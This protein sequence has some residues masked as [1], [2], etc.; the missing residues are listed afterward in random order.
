MK[1]QTFVRMCGVCVILQG[2]LSLAQVTTGTI[3]GTVTDPTGAVIPG[4]TITVRNVETGITRI[5]STDAA[6]RYTA[7]QLGLGG[8]E[9]TAGTAGFQ[10]TVR[11]G[12]ELTVGRQAVVDFTLRVGAVAETVTVTGEAPLLETTNATVADL[13]TESQM[14]DLPLN[15]RSFTNL[16]ALQ[17]GVVTDL[18]IPQGVF[19][20]G[21]R[22]SLNGARPQQSL[23]LLD[24]TDIVAPYSN[25]APVSV[26]F[27]ALGV[28]TIREFSV[29][30]N[31]Y[32]AQYGRAVGGI[33]SAVTR[34]GT[35]QLHGSLFEFLRNE[36]LDAKNFFDLPD[37]P[38]PPFKRNQFGGTIG[39]PIVRDNTFFFFSY[40]GL[41]QVL[42]TTDFGTVFSDET[43]LG[44]ITG[45]P[46][47]QS[48][49]TKE[50]AVVQNTV[51]VNPDIQPLI[52]IV[53]RGNGRY[54][55]DGIQEFLGSRL[56]RGRESYYMF[57]IDQRI[58]DNDSLFGRWTGDHSSKEL[59]DAQFFADGS[60]RHTSTDD[61][62]FYGFLTVEWTRIISPT[63][64]N[65]ARAG[66][67][68]NN[69]R[70]CMCIEGT[71]IGVNEISHPDYPVGKI[72]AQLQIIPGIP[73]GGPWG[74]PGVDVPG[75]HNGIGRHTEG[76]DLDDPL[77]Y[78][79]NTFTF[80][81]SVRIAR[82][83]HS[84][85]IG[86]DVRRY[87]ENALQSVWGKGG[88][89]FRSP[90]RNFLTTGRPDLCLEGGTSSRDCRGL[91]TLTATGI[92]RPPDAYRG[93]RQTYTAFFIQDD[94]QLRS[95][96]TLNFGIRWEQITGPTEVNQK[97]ATILD[98]LRDE[99][100]TQLGDKPLFEMRDGLKGFSPRFGFA[101]SPDQNTSIR[102]GFGAFREMPLLY[103]Y[104]L[105]VF[106]PPFSDRLQIR[107]FPLDAWPNPLAG[108]DPAGARR[109]PLTVNHDYKY[110]YSL[111][112]NLGI[113][114]QIGQTW[115][116]KVGYVGTRGISLVSINNL[117]QPAQELD[118]Q[119]VPFTPRNAPSP[120]PAI[121][122]TRS[123]GNFGDSW[124]N[125]LQL[126][127]Q[128]RF[129]YGI[130]F[131]LG[132]TWSKNIGDTGIGL[133]G[134]ETPGGDSQQ[135]GSLWDWKTLDRSL[136]AQDTRHNFTFNFSYDLPIGQGR[137]FGGNMGSVANAI[138]GGWQ[139]N[140]IFR[141]R[142]GLPMT[143]SGGGYSRNS[144]CRTCEIRPNLKPG[145]DNN[146]VRDNWDPNAPTL[147][148]AYFDVTQFE[149]VPTSYYG[150]VGKHT[151][152][153]P[154]LTTVDFSIF[155][156]F[157]LGEAKNIQFR[158]EFFNLPNHPNFARPRA[159]VFR[160]NGRIDPRVGK[161]TQARTSR[162]I[163]LAFKFEF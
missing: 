64:I 66:F 48:S 87:Q 70:Q 105:A 132:Y 59:S 86:V 159:G 138:L 56:Q 13:V 47:G 72:P 98:V 22:M 69:N 160:T 78:I 34:S 53:P 4:S 33:M 109:Q 163:Q 6:G 106:Y 81:D 43:R 154:G 116:A 62:G 50:E 137:F 140:S 152:T 60:G 40:E 114:R 18:G 92:T 90:M 38:I 65:I 162:Q 61:D 120:N 149:V 94:Y 161:I 2:V 123:Y 108:I 5:I 101:Y 150:N 148:S 52:G 145:G 97:V 35:N 44:I 99:D 84:V 75:G 54:L 7:Q 88:T 110:P 144:Y 128:K 129:S 131:N 49:C 122:S 93:F 156:M 28:D 115:V 31:N 139:L 113:E 127:L 77:E 124:Y 25:V 12:I 9:V 143:I 16:V 133:K 135:V 30:Q 118:D 51:T 117:L 155:K 126:R 142:T 96:L 130:D 146:P 125:A 89:N 29:L 102:G 83:G 71:N 14:R 11:A 121:H 136:V 17:P 68:R 3:S 95:N 157:N 119:G 104:Q 91:N 76:A 100:W 147:E 80:A 153:T 32:G 57:R 37:D 46:E 27:Q 141:T 36:K 26:M 45:C 8:Y 39:G 111:Q 134:A 79:D 24:G 55:N 85:D 1:V 58:S 42:G 15:G 73:F 67:A 63:V 20:G 103:S 10:T 23:Y 82:A 74:M 151:L 107:S 19:Q 21:G 158:A 112:W 41:R